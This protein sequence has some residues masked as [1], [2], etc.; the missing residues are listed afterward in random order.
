MFRD[1]TAEREADERQQFLLQAVDELTSSLDYETTLAAVARLAVPTL[2]DWCA[3]DIIEEGDQL[4]RVAT[5][6]ID[7]NKVAAVHELAKRY[8]PD[9]RSKTG[10]HEILR[11]GRGPAHRRDSARAAHRRGGRRGAPAPDRRPAAAL[12]R[13]RP[14]HRARQGHGGHQPGDGGVNRIY[15]EADLAFAR[16]LADRAALAIDNA[17]LFREAERARAALAAQLATEEQRR[18]DAEEQARFAETFVAMLGHDLR[19]PLNAILM[20]TR[21]LERSPRRRT[22]QPRSSAFARARCACRTWWPSS[23]T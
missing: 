6:H 2:A 12:V 3:V 7:P 11:T 16:A 10:T 1:V 22:R 8:P 23:S 21:L 18:A 5:A 19:N 13:G 15:G 14:A 4:K 20:T 9:P 17:R